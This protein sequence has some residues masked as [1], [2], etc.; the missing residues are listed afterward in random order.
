[1]LGSTRAL[2]RMWVGRWPRTGR[3]GCKPHVAQPRPGAPEARGA[4]TQLGTSCLQARARQG[5]AGQGRAGTRRGRGGWPSNPPPQRGDSSAST[6]CAGAALTKVARVRHWVIRKPNVHQVPPCLVLHKGQGWLEVGRGR[7]RGS[8]GHVWGDRSTVTK[9]PRGKR[10]LSP[11]V[12]M[13]RA[14]GTGAAPGAP[15]T[16]GTPCARQKDPP[17]GTWAGPSAP[18]RRAMG[19]STHGPASGGQ[20]SNDPA[21]HQ[22]L[23]THL[24]VHRHHDTLGVEGL[25]HAE[26]QGHIAGECNGP[27]DGRGERAGKGGGG[28]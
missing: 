28:Q 17:R 10:G 5:R 19:R 24:G 22:P 4:P 21:N 6:T 9:T 8:E 27:S 26:V 18:G 25:R 12:P 15:T 7:G 20:R 2:P 14:W 11:R 13:P 1:M 16:E 23:R 3:R